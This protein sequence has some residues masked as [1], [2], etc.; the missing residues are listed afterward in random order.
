MWDFVFLQF[1]G[2]ITFLEYAFATSVGP[3]Y[4]RWTQLHLKAMLGDD[5]IMAAPLKRLQKYSEPGKLSKAKPKDLCAGIDD[6]RLCA[7]LEHTLH[8]ARDLRA[9]PFTVPAELKAKQMVASRWRKADWRKMIKVI[10][11]GDQAQWAPVSNG[12]I[13]EL[14][15]GGWEVEHAANY[16]MQGGRDLKTALDLEG[17]KCPDMNSMVIIEAILI[18]I[19]SYE[20][21]FD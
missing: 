13:K 5:G 11:D 6:P 10:H 21:A 9:K 8:V 20:T 12:I 16:F 1:R 2:Q 7:C 15:K 4:H 19:N 14:E 18:Q 3:K 17:K